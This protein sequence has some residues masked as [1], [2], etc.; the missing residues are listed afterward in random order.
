ML[1]QPTAR[2]RLA[3]QALLWRAQCWWANPVPERQPR[4][5]PLRPESL[6]ARMDQAPLFTAL[7]RVEHDLFPYARRDDL[8]F[9]IEAESTA[10]HDLCA[11]VIAA[12]KEVYGIGGDLAGLLRQQGARMLRDGVAYMHLRWRKPPDGTTAPTGTATEPILPLLVPLF[13]NGVRTVRQRG[14]VVRYRITPARAHWWGSPTEIATTRP[15]TLAADA[16]VVLHLP[17]HR[18]GEPPLLRYVADYRREE[19]A[20]QVMLTATYA[21]ANPEDRRVRVEAARHREGGTTALLRAQELA[22]LR[23]YERAGASLLEYARIWTTE[24]PNL[25]EYYLAWQHIESRQRL[26]RARNAILD[27]FAAQVLQRTLERNGFHGRVRLRADGF[28]TDAALDVLLEQYT[29]GIIT[30]D[31]LW[32]QAEPTR[33]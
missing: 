9:V 15:Y 22:N 16:M 25:T 5:L 24:E 21:Q 27:Q 6:L 2:L 13:A 26:S 31:E 7:D 1:L 18:E 10:A 28:P 3:T 30:L 11:Q 33:S 29:E 14:S 8:R 17:G 32:Q 23:L 20:T 12:R 19:I 4:R